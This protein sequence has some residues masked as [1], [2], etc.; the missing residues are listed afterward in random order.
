MAI[1]AAHLMVRIDGDDS[2]AQAAMGRADK[3]LGRLV[4]SASRGSMIF[5]AALAGGLFASAKAGMSFEKSMVESTAIM[6]VTEEQ[7][8]RMAQAARDLAKDTVFS[9]NELGDA[10]YYLA[11][12]GMDAEQSIGALPQVAAFATAGQFDLALATDLLTDAQS[13]LGLSSEDAAENLENMTRVGDVLVKAN[14]LANA[15]VQQFSEALTNK[16]AAAL[17]TVGKDV[18]EGAAVLAAFADKGLKGAAAGEALHM[19]TRDLQTAAL[20]NADAFKEAGVAVYDADGEMRNYADITGD[21][22]K[23]LG[24]MSDAQKKAE[25]SALGFTDR[26]QGALLT[27]LGSSE[28]IREYEGELRNAGGVTDQVANDQ[29]QNLTDQIKIMISKFADVGI[30]VYEDFVKPLMTKAVAAAEVFADKLGW[31]AENFGKIDPAVLGG[32]AGA[33]AG[34][35]V[36]ALVTA[37][38]AVWGVVAPLVPFLVAGAAL[39][40]LATLIADKFGGWSAVFAGAK[41][42]IEPLVNA[43]RDWIGWMKE[44]L[45]PIE[46]LGTTLAGTFGDSWVSDALG[47]MTEAFQ[48]LVESL[49]KTW[50]MMKDS[51]Q[52]A[53]DSLKNAW[54]G[55][56]P[57]LGVVAGVLAGVVATAIG[58]VIGLVSGFARAFGP[59]VRAIGGLVAIVANVFNLIIG[60]FTGDTDR[61]KAAAGN[62]IQGIVDVFAGLWGAVSGFVTG[63][64]EGVVGFFTG[65]YETLVGSSI[66]PDMITDIVTWFASLPG[67][68]YAIV[69]AFVTRVVTFYVNLGKSIIKAVSGF[70]GKV[71]T[72][73][74]GLPGKVAGA[75]SGLASKA[76][77]KFV[78]IATKVLTW[79][80]EFRLKVVKWFKGVGS[81]L[82]NGIKTGIT[83][84]WSS[85]TSWFRDKISA[86][87]AIVKKALGISS[88]SKVF[89]GLAKEIPAGLVK[90]IGTGTTAVGNAVKALVPVDSVARAMRGLSSALEVPSGTLALSGASTGGRAN[91]G[92]P[93]GNSGDTFT[94]HI[95]ARGATDPAAVKRATKEA[96]AEAMSEYVRRGRLRALSTS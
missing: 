49:K 29:V 8:K 93:R 70:I 16:A 5:G 13:A 44:G 37:A 35:L 64:I 55:L 17:R 66:I 59:L 12:A 3:G 1:T 6:D 95:D 72:W 89:A 23:R 19:V 87:P 94:F 43:F 48:P 71:V 34:L 73:F 10:Y 61:I 88:P 79:R 76:L 40:A 52:P 50:E 62:I 51:L 36:P 26:S 46:A 69:S 25:L 63:F 74:K 4:K 82:V 77:A 14:T 7:T 60:I 67:K 30:T 31:L 33:I 9:A 56:K 78:E 83:N 47:R 80:N 11:S 68:V 28:A 39:G 41:E 2:G 86:L 21:L 96:V 18:E 24:G 75:L 54:D 38:A 58:V 85:L 65:L 15:S 91:L 20:K 32:I 53:L 22:E 81:S 84:G 45:N 90:G 27:L 42:V 57:V 92:A